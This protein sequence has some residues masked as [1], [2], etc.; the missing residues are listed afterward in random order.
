MKW[1][2][3]DSAEGLLGITS[4]A[5]A[6]SGDARLSDVGSLLW[7]ILRQSVPC[8]AIALFLIDD[9]RGHVAVRYAAGD[10]AETIRQVARPIGTGIAGAVAVHWKT[11]VNSDPAFD[12]GKCAIDPEHP[13]RSCLAV[14]LVDGESLIA[15]LAVYSAV[16]S[17]YTDDHA[18][19]LDLVAPKLAASVV[20]MAILDEDTRAPKAPAMTA[21]HLVKPVAPAAPVT[22][23]AP[24]QDPPAARVARAPRMR[25]AKQAAGSQRPRSMPAGPTG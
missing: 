7:M 19:L 1:L 5:R 14:P 10:H 17:A 6:M 13:L 16:E 24:R 11:M 2:T 12:L 9:E 20:D 4:L 25:V 18:R 8:D 23:E 21:L 15:I 3:R 22:P